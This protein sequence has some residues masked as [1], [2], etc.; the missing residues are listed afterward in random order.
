MK[1][2]GLVKS[3]RDKRV[4]NLALRG[5]KSNPHNGVGYVIHPKLIDAVADWL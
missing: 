2:L 1:A 5:G 4:Y 3:I